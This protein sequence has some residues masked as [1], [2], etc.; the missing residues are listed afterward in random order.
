MSY[1]PFFHPFRTTP[2]SPMTR[3]Q[4][5]TLTVEGKGQVSAAP[6]EAI[7]RIGFV[8]ENEDVEKAQAENTTL[9]QK[10]LAALKAVGIQEEDIQTVSYIVQPIYEFKEGTSLLKGYKVQHIFE[11]TIR[12]LKDVGAVYETVI[13]AGANIAE[14]IQFV[15]SNRE[16]YYQQALQ[17]AMKNAT[18]KAVK[19]GQQIGVKINN[20]PTKVTEN[21]TSVSPREYAFSLS[22]ESAL[23]AAPPIERSKLEIDA[24]VTALFK[25]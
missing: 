3:T 22:S 7:I 2:H 23:Q 1:Y 18:E 9:A 6:D 15:V 21:S 17:L 14:N 11:V 8:T 24:S 16:I 5:G 10:G 13:A 20:I 12:D 4:Q 19:L 25:Y